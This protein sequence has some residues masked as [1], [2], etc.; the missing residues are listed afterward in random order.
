MRMG[1]GDEHG[2]IN[3]RKWDRR[4][5]T[6]DEKRFAFMRFMQGR[7]IDL[8]DLKPGL[9]VL[10]VGCGT[11]WAIRR[12]ADMARGQGKFCGIDISPGMIERAVARRGEGIEFRTGN[13][14]Q[15]SYPDGT[16]DRIM[17]TNSFHHYQN[18][19]RA[20]SEFS[21]VL[22]PGGRLFITDLTSD[23]P[24]AKL[25]DRRQRKR[26]PAHVRFHDTAEF[27]EYFSRAG[28]HYRET[29]TITITM[30]KVHIAQK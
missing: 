9:A 14:E 16:F 24:I 27:K 29:R 13:A 26:E 23:G 30:M 1:T 19:Q 12:A 28:L 3:A 8:M 11:G 2:D 10:D 21:R 17:C 6:Y 25:M 15:L 20:V 7:T 22:K 5:E 18:P 4:A